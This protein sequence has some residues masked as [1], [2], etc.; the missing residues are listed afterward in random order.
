MK[1]LAIECLVKKAMAWTGAP[2]SP[3]LA[4]STAANNLA[5]KYRANL[6]ETARQGSSSRDR[7]AFDA[8]LRAW[9]DPGTTAIRQ[10]ILHGLS[11]PGQPGRQT[12]R[13][14][15]GL[16]ILEDA[17]AR[18]GQHRQQLEKPLSD[19]DARVRDLIQGD[20]YIPR[21]GQDIGDR[22]LGLGLLHDRT[23]NQS[24]HVLA[25]T[26][27]DYPMRAELE[28]HLQAIKR[29]PRLIG[30][31]TEQLAK[32]Q[33]QVAGSYAMIQA[34]PEPLRERMLQAPAEMNQSRYLQ[35]G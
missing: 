11:L 14:P 28:S 22:Y 26:Q 15:A 5:S 7:S 8:A 34:K 35:V 32:A 25:H 20:K 9:H 33:Q 1:Y 27:Y 24:G 30:W 12:T 29:D 17:L 13:T 2:R 18:H 6:A 19:I 31:T 23:G 21:T 3:D 16:F 10:P 4:A